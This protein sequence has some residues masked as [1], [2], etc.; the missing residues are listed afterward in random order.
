MK[1][2]FGISSLITSFTSWIILL[3]I[4]KFVAYL[5]NGSGNELLGIYGAVAL[6]STA[7]ILLAVIIFLSVISIKK[8]EDKIYGI[9]AIIV[10]LFTPLIYAL[11]YKYII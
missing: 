4:I 5:N 9:L 11:L 1:N 2:K 8:R 6:Y 3:S 7:L 10:F